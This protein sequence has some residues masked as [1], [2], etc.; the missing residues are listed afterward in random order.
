MTI[1]IGILCDDGIVIGSDSSATFSAGQVPTIE[2]PIKK[3]YVVGNDLIFAGTGP[4]GLGQRFAAILQQFRSRPEFPQADCLAVV[5]HISK[6]AIEDL[7]FTYGS[8]GQFGA[9]VAFTSSNQLYLCEFAIP[10]FQPEFKM[11]DIWFVSMGSGQPI[12]DP[13]LGLMR[14][15]FFKTSRPKLHEGIWIVTWTLEHAIELNTG[16]INGPI[17]IAILT[18]KAPD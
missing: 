6:A 9:L 10:A 8:P 1:L 12:A 17:Q 11:D 13:F 3:V 7:R 2:Q 14:R 15:V 5:K 16:G 4:G 18:R